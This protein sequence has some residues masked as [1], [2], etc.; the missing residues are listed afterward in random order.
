[1]ATERLD[2]FVSKLMHDIG[3]K[4]SDLVLE[5]KYDARRQDYRLKINQT[6]PFFFVEEF[7]YKYLIHIGTESNNSRDFHITKRNDTL[8][9]DVYSSLL[10]IIKKQFNQ[11]LRY[12]EDQVVY[13][14]AKTSI[15]VRESIMDM[16]DAYMTMYFEGERITAFIRNGSLIFHPNISL[17]AIEKVFEAVTKYL[18]PFYK[19]LRE[20]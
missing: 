7:E 20:R 1:M 3:Y 17:D 9:I 5:K 18:V 16:D 4:M 11:T 2:T 19:R 10:P 12:L 8:E 13:T 15:V 6:L 14:D